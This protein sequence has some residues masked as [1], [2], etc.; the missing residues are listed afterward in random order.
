MLLWQTMTLQH[1]LKPEI[2]R[3]KTRPI[4]FNKRHCSRRR[5]SGLLGLIIE[6]QLVKCYDTAKYNEPLLSLVRPCGSN[7]MNNYKP[8]CMSWQK[9]V[10]KGAERGGY[11]RCVKIVN[12]RSGYFRCLIQPWYWQGGLLNDNICSPAHL[13]SISE[14][15]VVSI[16]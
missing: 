4:Y 11:N 2:P 3:K 1:Q 6:D 13:R 12:I 16:I 8:S 7:F 9:H 5:W 14:A 10:Y 15:R